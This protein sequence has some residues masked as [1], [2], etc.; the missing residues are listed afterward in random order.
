MCPSSYSTVLWAGWTRHP[1]PAV[2]KNANLIRDHTQGTSG[3]LYTRRVVC[4]SYT[5]VPSSRPALWICFSVDPRSTR[6]CLQL[7]IYTMC[8]HLPLIFISSVACLKLAKG[9]KRT[10]PISYDWF[11]GLSA[12]TLVRFGFSTPRTNHTSTKYRMIQNKSQKTQN[13]IKDSKNI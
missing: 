6:P 10:F 1:W 13:G 11:K 4:D 5:E 8:Y 3:T 2:K 7:A 9:A 12:K